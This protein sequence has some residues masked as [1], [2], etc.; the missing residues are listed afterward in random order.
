MNWEDEG[1]LLSKNKFRENANIINI[2][3]KN[4]GKISGIIYGGNSRKIKNFLQ[5]SNKLFV[6]FNAKNEN[7]LG[8]FKPEIISPIAPKY[9]DDKLRSSCILSLTSL[10]NN[11]LPES[12]PNKKIYD[13]LDYLF[14]HLEEQFWIYK[15]IFWEY[16]L[17]KEI[18]FD[19]N[20]K[21]FKKNKNGLDFTSVVIDNTDYDIPN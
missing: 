17:I 16:N 5:I 19:V 15:Y 14:I 1:Y 13:S 4:H 7:Q 9:F 21:S 6:V 8:Y 10:L 18:G 12:Q 11:L 3:T 20:L 2:F